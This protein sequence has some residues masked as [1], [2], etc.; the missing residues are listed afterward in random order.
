MT[1]VVML[2][3]LG[4]GAYLQMLLPGLV[5]L[6]QARLPL[7]MAIVLYFSLTRETDVMLAAA[8]LAGWLQDSLSGIPLGYSM[9]L[10]CVIGFVAGRFRTLVVSDAPVT[11]FVFGAVAGAVL[12]LGLYV[13]LVRDGLLVY[14]GARLVLR[15]AGAGITG[16]VATYLTFAAGSSL[17]GLFRN[18]HRHENF[19]EIEWSV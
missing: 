11:Q 8:F 17:D 14:P 5:V 7:L 12:N 13:L 9:A 2:L 6:G 15:T 1:M 16:A 3:L 4:V 10:F 19:G 18:V